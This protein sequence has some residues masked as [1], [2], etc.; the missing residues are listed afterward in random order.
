MEFIPSIV[1]QLNKQRYQI[2]DL[3]QKPH[4]LALRGIF[5]MVGF[6]KSFEKHL[7]CEE[8]LGRVQSNI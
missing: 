5:E 3:M 1:I 7:N 4:I 8:L 2:S 6:L